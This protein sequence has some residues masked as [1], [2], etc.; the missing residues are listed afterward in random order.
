MK[1]DHLEK[2]TK[3][4]LEG[5][6]SLEE[7][8]Q[9]LHAKKYTASAMEDWSTFVAQHQIDVPK[10]VSEK[11][12]QQFITKKTNTFRQRLLVVSAAASVLLLFSIYLFKPQHKKQS[13]QEKDALLSQALQLLENTQPQKT[14]VIYESNMFIIYTTDK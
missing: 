7:E 14:Q 13:Y 4:Y 11:L 9:L 5:K 12:W 2:L 1:V 6:T 8:R 3:K 10:D